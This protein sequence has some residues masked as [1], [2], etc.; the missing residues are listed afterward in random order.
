MSGDDE[1]A[2]R[3][4]AEKLRAQISRYKKKDNVPDDESSAEPEEPRSDSHAGKSPR[5]FIQEKMRELDEKN[6]AP[7]E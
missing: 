1:V 2:R 4:R 7:T 6:D 5:E 3:E